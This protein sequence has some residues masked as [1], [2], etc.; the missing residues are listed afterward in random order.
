LPKTEEEKEHEQD[1]AKLISI[2]QQ[3]SVD[4]IVVAANCLEARKLKQVMEEI[5]L[6]M[7]NL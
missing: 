4:L 6:E 7:K 2:M 3:H 1:K 5:A